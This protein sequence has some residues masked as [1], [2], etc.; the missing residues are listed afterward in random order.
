MIKKISLILGSS[1]LLAVI[2]V[3]G[4]FVVQNTTLARAEAS[5][6][7]YWPSQHLIA[8]LNSDTQATVKNLNAHCTYKVGFASYKKFNENIEQQE[9]YNY[10][11]K[12]VG[13][14]QTVTLSITVPSCTAQI[15]VFE[16]DVITSFANGV[17]YANTGTANGEDRLLRGKNINS[18]NYCTHVS[19]GTLKVVKTVINDDGGTKHVSDF[20]LYIENTQVSSGQVLTLPKNWYNVREDNLSGYQAGNWGGDCNS[21]G[22]VYV[23]AGTNKTCTITNND[24]PTTTTTTH[25]N[26]NHHHSNNNHHHSNNSDLSA[27]CEASDD[28]AYVDEDITWKVFP[29]GGKGSYSYKWQGTDG[30]S[31]STKTVEY[32]YDT[33]GKKSA[34]VTV[35]SKGKSDKATCYVKIIE[36]SKPVPPK[37][38]VP[39]QTSAGIYLSQVPYTGVE[40]NMKVSLFI[41]G[42]LVWST[43]LAYFIIRRKARKHGL[44]VSQ[45]I[46]T[47]GGMKNT[48]AFGGIST[49]LPQMEV[50]PVTTEPQMVAPVVPPAPTFPINSEDFMSG[51]ESRARAQRMII[52]ADALNIIAA[53]TGREVAD[54]HGM[55]DKLATMHRS[56]LTDQND[57]VVLN[58]Q[59]VSL[60]L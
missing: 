21:D 35:Y 28:K 41:A 34:T 44:T 27:Y 17:R 57:W 25:T 32:S 42:I 13:P 18:N 58:A 30:L 52:S 3:S 15:D 2:A 31:G 10:T 5:E 49:R 43:A 46:T 8:T 53:V 55:V 51:L 54:A 60:A 16:G 38:E 4:Y 39:P 36:R 50:M 22:R 40:G 12:T 19:T 9:L 37:Y 14:N 48:M 59:K 11:Y 26:N 29:S 23:E 20:N 47:D 1:V 6:C 56:T 7:E 24:I 45:F 33:P